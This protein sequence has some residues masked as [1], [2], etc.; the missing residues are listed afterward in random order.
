LAQVEQLG[1]TMK[2]GDHGRY[3]FDLVGE[4]RSWQLLRQ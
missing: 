4:G 1:A 3:L 2:N